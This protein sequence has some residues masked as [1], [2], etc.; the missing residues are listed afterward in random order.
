MPGRWQVLP[1]GD[2]QRVIRLDVIAPGQK[3]AFDAV[4]AR[5]YQDWKDA[6]MQQQRTVAL[7]ELGRKY[8]LR[9]AEV[10]K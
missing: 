4:Q 5:V 9:Q 6:S 1:G 10:G 3:V 7:R 2:G 8:T